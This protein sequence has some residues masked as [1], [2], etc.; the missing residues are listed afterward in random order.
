MADTRKR[1]Y[2]GMALNNKKKT[3]ENILR[4]DLL[5]DWT[6]VQTAKCNTHLHN[7]ELVRFQFGEINS[8]RHESHET[9]QRMSELT[10]S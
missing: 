10:P 8:Q 2:V 3:Y 1:I 6:L 9:A 5:P 7:V 4:Y